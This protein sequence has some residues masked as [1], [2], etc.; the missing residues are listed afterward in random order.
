LK[1][2]GRPAGLKSLSQLY[3]S[4]VVA[5]H[6][7]GGPLAVAQQR[8]WNRAFE[9]SS[10]ALFAVLLGL[11][12]TRHE[13]WRDEVQAWLIARDSTSLPNLFHNMR[14]EGHPALWQLILFVPAHLSQNPVGIQVINYVFAVVEAWLILSA[15]KVPWFIRILTA[16]SFFVFYQYGAVARNYMLAML[17]L[18]AAARCLLEERQHR[19]LALVLLALAINTHFFAIPIALLFALQMFFLA[20]LRCRKDIG[21]L[22]RDFG[23]LMASALLL[24][25]VAVSYCTMRPPHDSYTPHYGL[26]HHSLVYYFQ[27]SDS[28][29]LQLFFPPIHFT[30]HLYDWL[31]PRPATTAAV[32]ILLF[33]LLAAAFRTALARYG[34]LIASALEYLIIVVTLHKPTPYHFGMIFVVFILALLIDFYAPPNPDAGRWLPKPVAL[35]VFV[36]FLALQTWRSVKASEADWQFPFSGAEQTSSWLQHAGLDKYPL[37]VQPDFGG[38]ALLGYLE[39]KT[40]YY[41][42]CRCVGSFTVWKTGRDPDRV[43]SENELESLSRAHRSPVIVVSGWE[44]PEATSRGLGLRMLWTSPGDSLAGERFYVYE[45]I[46]P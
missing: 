25:T 28:Q 15:R 20:R 8:I 30:A 46:G 10:L 42:T 40:A 21:K 31:A 34:F 43:V 4:T 32:S 5:P 27:A 12:T 18:T 13:M 37:V 7:S 9:W 14:Y 11:V 36:A 23:S 26:E 45:R 41:P 29:V 1:R 22:F 16:F 24:V 35:A 3:D 17:L 44:L 33:L 2:L 6:A 38:A 19:K 39:Q